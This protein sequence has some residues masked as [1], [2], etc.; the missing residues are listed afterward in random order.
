[1]NLRLIKT[2]FQIGSAHGVLLELHGDCARIGS[3]ELMLP[4]YD[5]AVDAAI[6]TLVSQASRHGVRIAGAKR[7]ALFHEIEM[8]AVV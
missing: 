6:G 2:A 3:T 1:M 4:A 5:D 7:Q 8:G